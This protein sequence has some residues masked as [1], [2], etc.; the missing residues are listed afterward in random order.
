MFLALGETQL[1][2]WEAPQTSASFQ[3]AGAHSSGGSGTVVHRDG[4]EFGYVKLSVVGGD[5]GS[6]TC[7]DNDG[8]NYELR[9][10]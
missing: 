7:Y 8:L 2:F 3:W 5:G 6:L 1:F 9:C 4:I 10:Q